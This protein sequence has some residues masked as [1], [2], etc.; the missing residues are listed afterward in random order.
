[1]QKPLL[2]SWQESSRSLAGLFKDIND[3][4]VGLAG[5]LVSNLASKQWEKMTRAAIQITKEI[6]NTGKKGL[7]DV[8][9]IGFPTRI[10]SDSDIRSFRELSDI[11][12]AALENILESQFSMSTSYVSLFSDYTENL[13]DSR[14]FD[15]VV[16]T[17]FDYLS[18]LMTTVKNGTLDSLKVSESIKT[19]LVAW[20]ENS[21][22]VLGEYP[23][24]VTQ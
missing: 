15:D 24:S 9:A 8:S 2:Q 14:N 23:P 22:Q 11:Y 10:P 19:A 1:M 4:N 17:N 21:L 6:G 18:N 5:E 13:K 7:F 16:A 12:Q 3:K 20:S